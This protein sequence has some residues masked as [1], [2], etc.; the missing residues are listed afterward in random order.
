[1][2]NC[3]YCRSV[4]LPGDTICYS[5]GRVL[6]NIKSPNFAAEQQFNRGNVETTYMKTKKPTKSGM[7][8]THK[9]KRRN[10]L[11]RRKNR[12]RSVIMLSLVAFIML[13]PQAR[14]HVFEKWAGIKE[15]I[16]LAAAP[17][18]LYPVEATYTIGKTLDFYNEDGNSYAT[19]NLAIPSDVSSLYKENSTFSYTDGVT[20]NEVPS[21]IQKINS[22]YMFI[23]EEYVSIP[24]NGQPAISFEDRL[25]T[26]DGHS[27]WWPGVGPGVNECKIGN[28]V[29][30]NLSLGPKESA[31]VLF[32]VNLTSTSYSWWSSLTRVDS[33]VAGSSDGINIDRSGTFDDI[34]ERGSGSKLIQ[35]GAKQW[36]NRGGMIGEDGPYQDYAIDAIQFDIVQDTVDIIAA[37]IPDGR[38]DNAYAFARAAFDYLHKNVVYD[39]NAPIVARSGPA[40]LTASIGDCDEQTNAYFS[41]LRAKGIPGW[42]VFG[43]LTDSTYIDWEGHAWG[44]ILLPMSESWC[45]SRNIELNSC[46]V[47]GSV[48]VVNNKWLLHTPTAYIDWIEEADPSGSLVKSYYKPGVRCCDVDRTRSF[49]TLMNIDQD[50]WFETKGGTFQVKKLA[51]NLR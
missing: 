40:C 8:M 27:V 13:S 15:Y 43:A 18:H 21:S 23:N 30:F 24:L 12:F 20:P 28:C 39:K 51:E 44:Y 50:E 38:S 7:V 6:A 34:S 2:G 45:N 42:Y 32:S 22:I 29:K 3:P 35:F 4:T 19:E 48:D 14:E 11:K 46:F 9:G 37:S 41:L 36:Y 5:C 1:M 26:S 25:I 17:Y 16:Q 47:E 33:R 31:K 49:D 10:I